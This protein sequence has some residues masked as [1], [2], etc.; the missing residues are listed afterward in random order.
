MNEPNI[1]LE[2]TRTICPQLPT[3]LIAVLLNKM[4]VH[5]FGTLCNSKAPIGTAD[6]FVQGLI[7]STITM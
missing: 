4:C 2:H 6:V 3:L 7:W 1:A 5:F